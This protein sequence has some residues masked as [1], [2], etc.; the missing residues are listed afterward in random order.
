MRVLGCRGGEL[1][2]GSN[3]EASISP[4]F[5]HGRVDGLVRRMRFYCSR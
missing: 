5:S 1:R 2:Y 4:F 3:V